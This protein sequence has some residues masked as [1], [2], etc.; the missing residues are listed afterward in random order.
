[1]E[2]PNSVGTHT[3]K[4]NMEKFFKYKNLNRFR[5]L[6]QIKLKESISDNKYMYMYLGI[7]HILHVNTYAIFLYFS[8]NRKLEKHQNNKMYD[9]F[10]EGVTLRTYCPAPGVLFVDVCLVVKEL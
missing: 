1:M 10:W 3:K 4:I 6:E 7:H 9:E 2:K 5:E 8:H